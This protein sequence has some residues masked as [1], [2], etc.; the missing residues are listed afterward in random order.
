MN[1]ITRKVCGAGSTTQTDSNADIELP[2][3]LS[4]LDPKIVELI[5]NEV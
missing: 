4:H 5:M 1:N 3:E 2:D